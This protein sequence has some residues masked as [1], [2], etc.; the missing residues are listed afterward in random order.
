MQETQ[1]ERERM[2]QEEYE[3]RSPLAY[4]VTGQSFVAGAQLQTL[5]PDLASYFKVEEGVLVTEILEDTP[6]A[7]AGLR[8][9]DVIVRVGGEAVTSVDDLRFGIGYF[10]RPLRLRVVRKGESV[11]IVIR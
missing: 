11:E 3:L 10:E 6:A 1:A 4:I 8:S 5:N 2:L 7:Q 9:G